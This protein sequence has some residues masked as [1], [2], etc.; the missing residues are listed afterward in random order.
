MGVVPFHVAWWCFQIISLCVAVL[1]YTSKC[2]VM[3]WHYVAE[4]DHRIL[5]L[6][7]SI[8]LIMD[9]VL[10]R[11]LVQWDM[12]DIIMGLMHNGEYTPFVVVVVNA[13]TQV[14]PDD[15]CAEVVGM[16]VSARRS[17]GAICG[18]SRWGRHCMHCVCVARVHSV[19]SL[20]HHMLGGRVANTDSLIVRWCLRL[21]II[22]K[23]NVDNCVQVFL[24][25]RV[26]VASSIGAASCQ[27]LSY[28][29][30]SDTL[31]G[32]MGDARGSGGRPVTSILCRLWMKPGSET[33]STLTG[34][35][36][37]H[38]LQHYKPTRR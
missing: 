4:L 15:V 18:K 17:V 10:L 22:F 29:E 12:Q 38:L 19:A 27:K 31:G 32:A 7:V 20:W 14:L 11:S 21:S 30:S 5:R 9:W 1:F 23:I 25:L 36:R 33:A 34:S 24:I 13:D 2:V 3:V 37:G 28:R 6:V 16:S 8:Y 26:T 35:R